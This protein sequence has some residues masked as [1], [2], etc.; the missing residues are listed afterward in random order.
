LRIRSLFIFL[1]ESKGSE[2][3][4]I[5]KGKESEPQQVDAALVP[6]RNTDAAPQFSLGYDNLF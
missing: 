3:K 2:D 5:A 1:F 6:R 4:A